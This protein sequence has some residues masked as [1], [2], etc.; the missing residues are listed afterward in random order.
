MFKTLW[1]TPFGVI[2]SIGNNIKPMKKQL[3]M[4]AII[5]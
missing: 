2:D 3:D 5:Q 4:A 1:L